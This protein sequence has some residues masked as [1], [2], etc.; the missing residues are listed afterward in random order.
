[1]KLQVDDWWEER[2]FPQWKELSHLELHPWLSSGQAALKEDAI[3]AACEAWWCQEDGWQRWRFQSATFQGELHCRCYD[4][5]CRYTLCVYLYKYQYN[6][7]SHKNSRESPEARAIYSYSLEMCR[8]I[9]CLL[10][11]EGLDPK[12]PSPWILDLDSEQQQFHWK[13]VAENVFSSAILVFLVV[14][15]LN[16]WWSRSSVVLN[17]PKKMIHYVLL[18][19]GI[20]PQ[21]FSQTTLMRRKGQKQARYRNHEATGGSSSGRIAEGNAPTSSRSFGT[22]SGRWNPEFPVGGRV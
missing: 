19:S 12:L 4:I 2:V 10:S 22:E 8:T 15:L 14:F 16:G 11:L 13:K 21:H 9:F 5:Q 7:L 3:K 1:M 17:K 6:I 20:V 18:R